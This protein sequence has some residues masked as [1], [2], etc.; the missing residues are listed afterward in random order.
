MS[1]HVYKSVEV[2]G[3]SSESIDDA[4]RT[5]V[6]KASQS[7]RHLEWFE[8]EDV[9]GH[10]QDGQVAHLQVTVKIGFRLE[11]SGRAMS[12]DTQTDRGERRRL[13]SDEF[14]DIIGRFASGV[15]VITAQHE[16]QPLRHDG[17]RRQL[18]V[19]RARRCC[20]SA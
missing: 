8:V 20:S 14:R 5:A 15:T 7:L 18:A 6:A 19:A 13:D 17:E 11:R 4:I 1:D 10:L 16:D 3:S 12:T 9:R 2:T